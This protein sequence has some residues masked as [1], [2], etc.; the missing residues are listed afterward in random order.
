MHDNGTPHFCE[1]CEGT[2]RHLQD[3]AVPLYDPPRR[4]SSYTR[5]WT[6]QQQLRRCYY[7]KILVWNQSASYRIA[8]NSCDPVGGT[9]TQQTA[10]GPQ[11]FTIT[12]FCMQ[13]RFMTD[14]DRPHASTPWLHISASLLWTLLSPPCCCWQARAWTHD[15]SATFKRVP[16]VSVTSSFPRRTL[17]ANRRIG[18]IC[19]TCQVHLVLKLQQMCRADSPPTVPPCELQCMFL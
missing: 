19:F 17:E 6:Q 3:A 8:C 12:V 14:L 1:V 4:G 16:C 18:V 7:V 9:R 15:S 2:V 11:S 5:K 10:L 13:W